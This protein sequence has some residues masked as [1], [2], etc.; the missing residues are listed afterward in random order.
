[1]QEATVADP[2]RAPCHTPSVRSV[3]SHKDKLR[4]VP[5][6][7]RPESRGYYLSFLLSTAGL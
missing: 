1:M 7:Q 4:L 5:D 2:S 6:W 3:F